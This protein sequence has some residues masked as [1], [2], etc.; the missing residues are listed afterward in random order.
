MKDVMA[1]SATSRA[2]RGSF[3][4]FTLGYAEDV[5]STAPFL[6]VQRVTGLPGEVW[7]VDD[8]QRIRAFEDKDSAHRDGAK[9]LLRPKYWL[10]AVQAAQVEHRFGHFAAGRPICGTGGL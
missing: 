5:E 9:R 8:A 6:S 1:R 10:R 7:N 3:L 2:N 4:L